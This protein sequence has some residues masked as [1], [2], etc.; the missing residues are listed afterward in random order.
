MC[1]KKN[2]I[3]IV[4]TLH[5]Y[6]ANDLKGR[7]YRLLDKLLI[8]FFDEITTV[9]KKLQS[10]LKE[11]FIPEKRIAVI[12]N[13]LIID[14]YQIK[15]EGNTLREELGLSGDCVLIASIGRLSP[16]KGQEIFLR[17]SKDVIDENSETVLLI[18]GIGSEEGRLKEL[19]KQL[20]IS[21]NVLFIGFRKDMLN[22]YNGI[23]LVVQSSY[24]EGMPNVILESLLMEIPV[25]A[26]DVGGTSEIVANKVNGIL[27]EPG[28]VTEIQVKIL[29][30]F[31]QREFYKTMAKR[32]KLDIAEKFNFDMRTRQQMDIYHK[33]IK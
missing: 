3:P 13:A 17:A 28:S 16:E 1:A 6:I 8:R 33:M 19:A 22:V 20:G 30:F 2:K 26:T 25:I 14:R 23:D 15:R 10:Q 31:K 11:S 32:G 9:S 12:N 21:S 18:I 5:G 4:V 7:I 27:I 29:E 24:T